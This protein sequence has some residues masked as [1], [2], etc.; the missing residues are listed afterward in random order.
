[1]TK[2]L[3]KLTRLI[4]WALLLFPLFTYAQCQTQAQSLYGA[5]KTYRERINSATALE[6]LT[7]YFS[8]NFNSYYTGKL[9]NAENADSKSRYLTQYWDNL[10]T[11]KDIVIVYDYALTCKTRD[12][13]RAILTL[14]AILD[15]PYAVVQPRA[16]LWA[17]K[18]HYVNEGQQWLIDSFEY[19]QSRIERAFEEQQIVDNFVVIR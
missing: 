10:N 8:A 13:D 14:L 2:F 7:G 17:V 16:E 18:I 12:Q 11:A 1:M 6:H 19:E 9:A 3:R 4:C 5:F 15:Q